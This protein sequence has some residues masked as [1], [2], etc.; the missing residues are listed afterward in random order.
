MFK[1]LVWLQWFALISLI[2]CNFLAKGFL[3]A[4]KFCPEKNSQ[5]I[6]CDLTLG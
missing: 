5:F 3:W 4:N 2:F 1:N 6:R